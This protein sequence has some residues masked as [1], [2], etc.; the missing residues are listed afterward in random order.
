M[1]EAEILADYPDLEAEDLRA[2]HDQAGNVGAPDKDRQGATR[3]H[4]QRT[5]ATTC[6]PISKPLM[7]PFAE[8][9]AVQL[10]KAHPECGLGVGAL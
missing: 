7:K 9:T 5:W 4:P 1:S 3:H 10:Q 8:L 2:C 6:T